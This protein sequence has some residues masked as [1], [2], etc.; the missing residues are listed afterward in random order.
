MMSN[1]VST[2]KNY[3]ALA[4]IYDDVMV[5]V[6]YE[7]WTDYIDEIIYQYHPEAQSVLELACG[8]GTMALSLE[9]L[10]AYKITA[11][12]GSPEMI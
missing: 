1:Q 6:D 8:T 5:E 9:E 2:Q 7:T 12:D 3:S 4:Q 10:A 11:T